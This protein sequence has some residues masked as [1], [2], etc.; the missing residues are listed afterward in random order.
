MARNPAALANRA[1]NRQ[2]RRLQS[3]ESRLED[4]EGDLDSVRTGGRARPEPASRAARLS[5]WLILAGVVLILAAIV[6][7]V[8]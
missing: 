4:L 3:L 8:V 2:E 5:R 6:L 1:R 7:A